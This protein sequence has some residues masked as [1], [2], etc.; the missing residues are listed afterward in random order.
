VWLDVAPDRLN[1]LGE[2][3]VNLAKFHKAALDL[4]ARTE[5]CLS[6]AE[7]AE[8]PSGSL[9]IKWEELVDSMERPVTFYDERSSRRPLLPIQ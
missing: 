3:D 4:R 5:E 8:R 2:L 9:E 1:E 7:Q 6:R